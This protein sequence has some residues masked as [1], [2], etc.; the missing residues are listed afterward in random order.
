VEV[1]EATAAHSAKTILA[2]VVLDGLTRLKACGL[3]LSNFIAQWSAPM[4]AAC[5]RRAG[6]RA[7]SSFQL[8]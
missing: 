2:P 7:L 1:F 3:G 8:T 6:R 4:A 5:R